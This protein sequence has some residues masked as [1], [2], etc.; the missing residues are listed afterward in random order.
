MELLSL[1]SE[2][3]PAVTAA[4]I[5]VAVMIVLA[6]NSQVREARSAPFLTTL[7]TVL[8]PFVT[9]T[10]KPYVVLSLQYAVHHVMYSYQQLQHERYSYVHVII[11]RTHLTCIIALHVQAQQQIAASLSRAWTNG[12]QAAEIL[13]ESLLR[14]QT[15]A[16]GTAA[17]A[18]AATA[19]AAAAVVVVVDR[20]TQSLTA[21]LSEAD[22][23]H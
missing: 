15:T 20:Q 10:I 22:S 2:L 19:A 23:P 18:V 4:V 12:Q 21:W 7:I 8:H 1:V 13:V 17:P 5:A 6:V 11:M 16:A 9:T 3:S 14:L